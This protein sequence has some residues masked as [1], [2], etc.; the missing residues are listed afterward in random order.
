MFQEVL[1]LYPPAPGIAKESY[2]GME[3][4]GYSIPEGTRLLVNN[5]SKK[6]KEINKSCIDLC[7]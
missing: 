2:H 6:C 3:L 5:Y 7:V 1:R 4:A